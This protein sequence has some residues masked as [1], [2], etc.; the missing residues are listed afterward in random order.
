MARK[1]SALIGV[2]VS[3]KELRAVELSADGKSV[4]RFATM[5]LGNIGI[6]RG[7]PTDPNAFA[8]QLRNLFRDLAPTARSAVF[9]A[10]AIAIT[11]RVLDVPKVPDNELRVILDGEVQ[12]Y[13]IVRGF[14]GMFDHVRL[15][16]NAGDEESLPQALVMACEAVQ[17]N[18]IRD[19]AERARITRAAIEPSLLGLMRLAASRH[20]K[21]SLG[22]LAALSG[23][24]AE[25]A[26][27][28]NN[29]LKLY[30]RIDLGAEGGDDSFLRNMTG[31]VP[32]FLKS[33]K[34]L[35][36]SQLA[37][38]IKR[39]LDYVSRE[40]QDLGKAESLILAV[41]QPS[42]AGA[43]ESLSEALGLP[44]ELATAP[45]PGEDGIRFGAAYGL[46]LPAHAGHGLPQFDL[47]PY[48]PV[49]EAHQHQRKILATSLAFSIVI[50]AASLAGILWF[51]Q[52]ANKSAHRLDHLENE[53]ASLQQQ[54]IPEAE[55]R[56]AKLEQYRTLSAFGLPVPQI[57]DA[58]AEGLDP[59][60]GLKQIEITGTNLKVS[61]EAE[62]EASMIRTL[63]QIR[64]GRGFQ[65]AFIESFDQHSQSNRKFVEFRLS[66]SLGNAPLPGSA[67]P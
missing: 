52:K 12:H 60:T 45:L 2:D 61:G 5:S 38:E 63:N 20:G 13:G 41:S 50:I 56:Q 44:V 39:T 29:G 27:V 26:V 28:H 66:A 25:V 67:K 59:K 42:E 40:Y 53:L 54:Q 57:V 47:S 15:T 18:S 49:E 33:D 19:A 64:M 58:V 10:P 36:H 1:T 9:G 43:V 62:D 51:G 16:R 11:T 14:G 23:D 24:I 46:A 7:V 55:K 32:A 8:D 6:D 3:A 35:D 22:V 31:S 21:V 30:R 34:E 65:N 37:V 48:D 4:K 17:L